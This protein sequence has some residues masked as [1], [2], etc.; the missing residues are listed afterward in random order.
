MRKLLLSLAC[1]LFLAG[2]TLAVDAVFVK[3]DAEKKVLTVKEGDKEATYK[4][5]DKTKVSIVG[6]DGAKEAEIGVL[7]K[8]KE[9]KTKLDLTTD[10]D[11]VT[12]IK[13]KMGKKN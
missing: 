6:K 4:V 3:F 13:M 12:E 9:G 5:T 8:A 1:V 10:K 2:V 11:T 7:S